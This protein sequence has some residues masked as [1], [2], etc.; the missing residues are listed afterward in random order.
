MTN[1]NISLFLDIF[2][3]F[4]I[5]FDFRSISEHSLIVYILNKKQKYELVA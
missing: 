5:S 3:L 4:S 1:I 2:L